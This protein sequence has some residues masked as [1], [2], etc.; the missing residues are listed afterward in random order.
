MAGNSNQ[1]KRDKKHV[2]ESESVKIFTNIMPSHWVVRSFTERDYG[3]DLV[4]EIAEDDN[5]TGK[6]FTCQ[7][8]SIEKLKNLTCYNIN[9]SSFTYWYALPTTTFVFFI[10]IEN[11]SVYFRNIKDYIRQNYDKYKENKLKSIKFTNDML[12]S[13]LSSKEI[14]KVITEQYNK[15]QNRKNMEFMLI[16]FIRDFKNNLEI[17]KSHLWADPFLALSDFTNDDYEYIVMYHQFKEIWEFFDNNWDIK[18]LDEYIKE[19]W[20]MFPDS[21]A[22]MLFERQASDLSKVLIEKFI[23]IF[24]YIWHYITKNL[25]YWFDEYPYFT[26]LFLKSKNEYWRFLCENLQYFDFLTNTFN[27]DITDVPE[28]AN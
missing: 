10:E 8:K 23:H 2:M 11:K 19:G 20:N 21:Y 24:I 9:S 12:L 16:S 4:V 7:L 3:I 27:K 18:E 13:K 14:E 28:D 15:E 1:P 26:A 5:M 6:L 22:E 25:K 17:L